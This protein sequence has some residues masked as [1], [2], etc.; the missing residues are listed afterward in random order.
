MSVYKKLQ[1]ARLRLVNT[2]I[3]LA[4]DMT[5]KEWAIWTWLTI[6]GTKSAALTYSNSIVTATIAAHGYVDGDIVTI[7]GAV[8]TQYNGTFVISYIDANTFSY[9]PVTAPSVTPATGAILAAN[10]TESYF[11][12]TT[13]LDDGVYDQVLHESSGI[14]YGT[15]SALYQDNGV[16]INV[17]IRT[18]LF[19][20][21]NTNKKHFSKIEVVGD[22]INSTAYLRY[23]SDDYQ[24]FCGYRPV[25]LLQGRSMLR[26]CGSSRRRAFELKHADNTPFRVESLELDI[27]TGSE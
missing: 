13:Y 11:P 7:S 1:T 23:S 20:G 2:N 19:D 6:N 14:V 16:P 22:K 10:Y 24:S 5:I 15:S 17:K 8:Q 26:R 12:M 4:F 27:D 18:N 21:G 3:T 25:Y 9:I